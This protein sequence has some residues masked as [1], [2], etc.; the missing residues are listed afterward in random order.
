MGEIFPKLV[1]ADLPSLG[2]LTFKHCK[3]LADQWKQLGAFMRRWGLMHVAKFVVNHTDAQTYNIPTRRQR[4]G[5]R[6]TWRRPPA[7]AR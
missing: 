2:F 1:E 7:S 4:K 3:I 5:S 6:R